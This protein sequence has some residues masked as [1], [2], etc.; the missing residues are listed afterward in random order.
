M[1]EDTHAADTEAHAHAILDE[2]KR[3]KL[4]DPAAY[5]GRSDILDRVRDYEKQEL[6]T[7]QTISIASA[8][9]EDIEKLALLD[10]MTELYNHRTFLKELK[11]EL[12]RA[13]RYGHHVALCMIGIDGMDGI[14]AHYG[15]LT[16]DA[17][18]KVAAN[19][20][21]EGIREVDIAARYSN[22]EFVLALPQ[23]NAAGA[24]LLAER[25][26]VRCGNQAIN[27][28]WQA[29]SVTASVGVATFPQNASNYDE[30]IA[31]AWEALD[32]ARA[33]GGDRVFCV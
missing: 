12:N 18:A 10:S 15:T 26:R 21:R 7:Q 5:G 25:L 16:V 1:S 17:V 8:R 4:G 28:N 30:L 13:K 2:L 20:I 24:A 19:V 29:F 6:D 32:Y 22:N 33:R 11:A 27:H 31:R 14:R 9:G 3:Q 23:T